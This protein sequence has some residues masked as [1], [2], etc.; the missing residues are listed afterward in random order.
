MSNPTEREAEDN[1]E[2]END[3][4]PVTGTIT[5]TSYAAETNPYLTDKVPVQPD[6]QQFDDPMQP[7]YSNSDQ[8]LERDESEAIDQSNVLKGERLR[9]AKPRTANKY[10]EG[11]DENDLPGTVRGGTVGRSSTKPI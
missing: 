3:A 9:H 5:D 7:P 8:Q 4:S 6:D 2:R 11:P 1:Y 10:N